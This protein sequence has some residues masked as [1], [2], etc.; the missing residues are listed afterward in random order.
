MPNGSCVTDVTNLPGS[1]GVKISR[2]LSTDEMTFLTQ[3]Y[4][5]ET[6]QFVS[7]IIP[8]G[9]NNVKFSKNGLVWR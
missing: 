5:V 1:E 4:G 6:A 8:I 7:E 2:R 9:K 3:E